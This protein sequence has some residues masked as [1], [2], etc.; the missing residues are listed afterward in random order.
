MRTQRFTLTIH[1]GMWAFCAHE[2]PTGEHQWRPIAGAR[3]D[4][5]LE[6]LRPASEAGR[7]R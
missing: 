1:Q 6:R 2:G 5:L 3:L 7:K 4:T